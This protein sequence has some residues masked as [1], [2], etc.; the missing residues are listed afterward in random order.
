MT[1]AGGLSQRRV[2]HIWHEHGLKAHLSRTF[3]SGTIR[4][5]LKDWGEIIWLYLKGSL[6]EGGGR[7][8]RRPGNALLFF[9]DV[10]IAQFY[11][12]GELPLSAVLPLRNLSF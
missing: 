5:S 7:S 11:Q 3:K 8:A 6:D 12:P 9:S 2:R 4:S 1:E 10:A